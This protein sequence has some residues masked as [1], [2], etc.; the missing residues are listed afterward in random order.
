MVMTLLFGKIYVGL[1]V[2]KDDGL[3]ETELTLLFVAPL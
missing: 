1:E 2:N 3:G